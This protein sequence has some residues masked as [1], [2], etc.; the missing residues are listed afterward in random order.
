MPRFRALFLLALFIVNQA[1]CTSWQVPK[2]APQESVAQ[3]PEKKVR[4]TVKDEQGG[5]NPRAG[6]VLT[7]VRF[8]TDSIFGHD[9]KGQPVAYSLRQ[10]AT[11]E[12]RQ[13]DGLATAL[14]V[15]GIALP[16]VLLIVAAIALT[17]ID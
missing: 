4:I 9:P 5:W 17:Q 1:A 11:I 16:V 10:V 12:V 7:G 8:S 6:I 13:K 15:I 3:K 2:V 14:L